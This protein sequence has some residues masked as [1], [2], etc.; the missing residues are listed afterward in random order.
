MIIPTDIYQENTCS[1]IK[2]L[3]EAKHGFLNAQ[4]KTYIKFKNSIK[5]Y[6][7]LLISTI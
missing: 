4:F 3:I 5:T 1:S 2:L 7:D 6:I